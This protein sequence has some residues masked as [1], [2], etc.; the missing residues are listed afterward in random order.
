MAE[1]ASFCPDT[2]P[3][4]PQTPGGCAPGTSI[5][6]GMKTYEYNGPW[7]WENFRPM[8]IA[9]KCCGELWPD[10][11][12]MP[13]WFGEALDALQALR[14]AWGEP[15]VI[16]SGHRCGRHNAEVGGASG[17]RHLRVA[18]DC[19]IPADRQAE[20]IE[21]ARRAGFRGIGRYPRRGF[22]HIDMGPAREWRE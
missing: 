19:I 15:V 7:P 18:F 6:Y 11:A 17:S 20:F 13:D 21:K 22:V 14:D 8:E 1:A 16:S 3:S 10:N 12:D 4:T 9:C 2:T 5:R